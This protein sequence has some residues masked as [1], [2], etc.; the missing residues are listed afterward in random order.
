MYFL[1]KESVVKWMNVM[2]AFHL[3]DVYH[4]TDI[5]FPVMLREGDPTVDISLPQ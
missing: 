2:E 4:T 3:F 5:L 1:W